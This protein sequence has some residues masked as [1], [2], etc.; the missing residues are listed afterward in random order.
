MTDFYEHI[1]VVF[2]NLY[3]ESAFPSEGKPLQAL[4][5]DPADTSGFYTQAWNLL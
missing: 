5:L 3:Y 1:S 4:L 2:Y